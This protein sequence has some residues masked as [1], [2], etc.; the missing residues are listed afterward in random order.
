MPI[1]YT[2]TSAAFKDCLFNNIALHLLKNQTNLPIEI[3]NDPEDGSLASEL[4]QRFPNQD[5]L[6]DYF[7]QLVSISDD[8]AENDFLADKVSIIGIMLRST[9]AQQLINTTTETVTAKNKPLLEFKNSKLEVFKNMVE[10][11]KQAKIDLGAFIDVDVEY[12]VQFGPLFIAFQDN[13]NEL[14]YLD[15]NVLTTYWHTEGAALVMDYYGKLE[16][17]MDAT[18]ARLFLQQLNVPA[19]ITDIPAVGAEPNILQE[20][21]LST[22]GEPICP[23]IRL[24]LNVVVGHYYYAT[25]TESELITNY[26][27]SIK[28]AKSKVSA[29]LELA[30]PD[31]EKL[32]DAKKSQF[33]SIAAEL[34][35]QQ[36]SIN[37]KSEAMLNVLD[38]N[39]ELITDAKAEAQQRAKAEAQQ[40]NNNETHNPV[41]EDSHS[42]VSMA[43][44]DPTVIKQAEVAINV[45]ARDIK[46]EPTQAVQPNAFVSFI[47]TIWSNI[48]SFCS[49]VLNGFKTMKSMPNEEVND[50]NLAAQHSSEIKVR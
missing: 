43:Q 11:Y 24:G 40:K 10:A 50:N 44:A 39:I 32:V 16:Q 36:F 4:I 19:L 26:E 9:F 34:P 17:P 14:G 30:K 47:S 8:K 7:K 6:N 15:D 25:D 1:S 3:F 46:P 13:I 45:E 33:I 48:V 28:A 20:V 18:E 38:S 12:R 29:I 21:E 5:E 27:A 35:P 22:I 23:P 31:S 49:W 37:D 2:D 41:E 42:L